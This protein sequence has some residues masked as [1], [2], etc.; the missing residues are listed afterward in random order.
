MY[1]TTMR[2]LAIVA[3]LA[4]L[5]VAPHAHTAQSQSV[6]PQSSGLHIED[7]TTYTYWT[8]ANLS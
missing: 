2:M 1:E 6:V 7:F 4:L 3:L 5:G 8:L